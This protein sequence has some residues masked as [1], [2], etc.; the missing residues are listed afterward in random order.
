MGR[1]EDG[2]RSEIVGLRDAARCDR[3]ECPMKSGLGGNQ[4]RRV[5]VK[6]KSVVPG[7]V[8]RFEG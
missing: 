1:S 8:G 4:E 6:P 3:R 7:V 5:S 2:G